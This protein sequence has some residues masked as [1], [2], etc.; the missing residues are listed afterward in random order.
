[1][2]LHT[3]NFASQV[4]R[5]VAATGG[6]AMERKEKYLSVIICCTAGHAGEAAVTFMLGQF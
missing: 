6:F 5:R 4:K 2:G 3:T 1:M